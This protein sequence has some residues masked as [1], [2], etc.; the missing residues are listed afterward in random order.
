LAVANF[1]KLKAV[2]NGI[3]AIDVPTPQS[4]KTF[5]DKP[6]STSAWTN[7]PLSHNA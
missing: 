3:S 7:A 5:P 6:L 2:S 4:E 1:N